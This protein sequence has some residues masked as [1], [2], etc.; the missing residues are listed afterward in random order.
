M[1]KRNVSERHFRNLVAVAQADGVLDEKEKQFLL[2]RAA[3]L[4]L[5]SENIK[6]IINQAA[7]LNFEVP[8]NEE[9]M[10]EHLSDIV[11]ITMVNGVIEAKEYEVLIHVAEKLDMGKAELDQVIKMANVFED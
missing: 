9:D 3:E 7:S 8:G 2:E 4:G 5:Q 10:E 1:Q 11:C 6:T